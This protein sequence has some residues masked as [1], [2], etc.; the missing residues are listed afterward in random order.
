MFSPSERS[1]WK[2]ERGLQI[3][4]R[5]KEEEV[6]EVKTDQ[7]Q[8]E[9]SDTLKNDLITCVYTRTQMDMY[10]LFM[11]LQLDTWTSISY[12]RVNRDISPCE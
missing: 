4:R 7:E 10:V 5:W 6:V 8:W 3:C 11:Y 9:G 1:R 12:V 2:G